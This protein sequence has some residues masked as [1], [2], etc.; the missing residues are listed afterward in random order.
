MAEHVRIQENKT[1]GVT[2]TGQFVCNPA[3]DNIEGLQLVLVYM[4]FL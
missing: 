3:C 2:L 4:L 1:G